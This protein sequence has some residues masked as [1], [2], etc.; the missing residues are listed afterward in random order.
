MHPLEEQSQAGSEAS[1][2]CWERVGQST[3]TYERRQ[4]LC[5]VDRMQYEE[6]QR[7]EDPAVDAVAG[8]SLEPS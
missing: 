6:F 5:V 8:D 2:V 3:P 4:A 7:T 1:V